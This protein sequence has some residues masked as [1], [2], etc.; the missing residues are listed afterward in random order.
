LAEPFSIFSFYGLSFLRG[1]RGWVAAILAQ[2]VDVLAGGVSMC[3]IENQFDTIFIR[4]VQ[5]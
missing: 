4:Q 2:Y 1:D 3:Y 5:R